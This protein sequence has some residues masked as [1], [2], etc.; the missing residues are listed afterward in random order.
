MPLQPDLELAYIQELLACMGLNDKVEVRHDAIKGKGVYAK[1]SYKRGDVVW[2]ERPLVAMQHLSSAKGAP[3]CS[4]CFA[5][6]GSCE[7]QIGSRLLQQIRHQESLAEEESLEEEEEVDEDQIK[8]ANERY[9]KV[10]N[11]SINKVQTSGND[12]QV[13]GLSIDRTVVAGHGPLPSASAQATA[14]G[15]RKGGHIL[16]LLPPASHLL[17]TLRCGLL[18]QKRGRHHLCASNGGKR[19]LTVN[20]K[21]TV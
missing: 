17:L 15:R 19:S 11:S 9:D 2:E 12:G 13:K 5:Y 20:L 16:C 18:D 10:S 14:D 7:H 1:T 21:K 8:A 3:C 4:H 6:L